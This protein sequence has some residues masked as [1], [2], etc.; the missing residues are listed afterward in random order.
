MRTSLIVKKGILLIHRWTGIFFCLLFFM[1]F[2]SGIVMMYCEY[3]VLSTETRLQHLPVLHLEEIVIDPPTALRVANLSQPDQAVIT[4]LMGRPVYHFRYR[5]K[6]STIFADSGI[7]LSGLSE[8]IARKIASNWVGLDSANAHLVEKQVEQDQ[9]TVT[10][11]YR[12]YRPLWVYSWPSGET[13]YV[14]DVTGEVV[15]YTTRT[16]RLGAYFG[17]I[18]HWIYFTKLRKDA[19][20]WSLVV[21]S[22]SASGAAMTLFGIIAGIWLYSPSKR[23]RFQAEPTSIPF[24][25]QKRWHVI[26]GLLFG[27]SA[28]TWILSGMFSMSILKSGPEPIQAMLGQQLTGGTWKGSDWASYSPVSALGSVQ[29]SMRVH[30]LE[31]TRFGGQ[32]VYLAIENASHSALLLRNQAPAFMQNAD[33]LKSIIASAIYPFH[34][35]ESR[36]ITEYETYYIDRRHEKPL[37]AFYILTDAPGGMAFYVDLHTAKVV[38]SY[39]SKARWNRWLYHGLHSLDLPWLYRYR[40]LWDVI[41]IAFMAGGLA[42]SFTSVVIGYRRIRTKMK[43]MKRVLVHDPK[44]RKT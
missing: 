10:Q 12:A 33:A 2:A 30:E 32:P 13:V 17:A 19:A 41:V 40:P 43:R 34:I 11:K 29:S 27:L 36:T 18:P 22:L 14:S 23:Y 24:A 37:P 42:L 4:S 26:L 1:W 35:V 6:I 16:S 39:G 15:Q 21:I 25:G 31:F 28:F 5:N 44:N 8:P 7:A 20:N 9:W 38:Q 3:P